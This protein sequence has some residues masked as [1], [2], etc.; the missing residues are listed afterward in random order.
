MQE[1]E[2]FRKLYEKT[3]ADNNILEFHLERLQRHYI[4]CWKKALHR[5]FALAS[6]CI[7]NIYY[8]SSNQRLISAF[9]VQ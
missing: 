9:E 5:G 2:E 1:R 7:M 4:F 3:K 6:K 8:T